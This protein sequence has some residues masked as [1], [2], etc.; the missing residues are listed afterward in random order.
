MTFF[1]NVQ[2]D[3]Y[4]VDRFKKIGY[5]SDSQHRPYSLHK[6]AQCRHH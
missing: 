5:G 4:N 1:T 6:N 2:K 3:K